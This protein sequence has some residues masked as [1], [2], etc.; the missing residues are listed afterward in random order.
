[1]TRAATDINESYLLMIAE[2]GTT[3]QMETLVKSFRTVSRIEKFDMTANND[4]DLGTSE[5][6]KALNQ[7]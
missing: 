6:K 7:Q 4:A 1:M 2:Y 3:Q 5:E